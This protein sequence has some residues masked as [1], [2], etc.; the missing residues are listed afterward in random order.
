MKK[1]KFI[2]LVLIILMFSVG[3]A[4][5]DKV[6]DEVVE[7]PK[8]ETVEVVDVTYGDD[9]E[10]YFLVNDE[11]SFGI[12]KGVI[13]IND[14]QIKDQSL[15]FTFDSDFNVKYI[16]YSSSKNSILVQTD[17]YLYNLNLSIYEL[18]ELGEISEGVYG[19]I[20][21][22]TYLNDGYVYTKYNDLDDVY[23]VIFS[24]S[25]FSYDMDIASLEGHVLVDISEDMEMIFYKSEDD[26][27]VKNIAENYVDKID[28]KSII[29]KEIYFGEKTGKVIVLN[30]FDYN[31]L[32]DLSDIKDMYDVV[33]ENGIIFDPESET[34]KFG[35]NIGIENNI[36]SKITKK[37]LN[38]V[39]IIDAS[40]LVVAPG[41]IDML[42]F[43]PN[44]IGAKYKIGDGV[45]TNLSMH[46]CS[47]DFDKFFSYYERNPILINYGG[48]VFMYLIR[49]EAGI[50]RYTEPTQGQIEYIA[51]RTREEIEAGGLG[52]AFSPEYY[53]GTTPEEIKASILVAK[54]YGLAS[55]FHA[56]YSS[57]VGE[58]TSI[59]SVIE[60]VGYARELD[61]HMHFMHL[62]STGAT[63]CMEEALDM[64]N[65]ARDEGYN[66]TF[67][68]YP[69][70]S[71]AT[72]IGSARF[73][74][75]W[76]AKFGIT[77]SDLQIAGTSEFVTEDNFQQLRNDQ[78]IVVAY[79]MDDNEIIMALKED[80][81]MIGSDSI[82]D[83][84]PSFN[85]FRASGAFS[86]FIGRY[87]RDLDIMP[88]MQ[89]IRKTSYLTA[90]QLEDI[91]E[92]MKVRGRIKEGTIAD[93][94]IFDYK[95]IIDTSSAEIPASL[96]K[97]IEY[98]LVSGN[99]I[100]DQ[101]K[102][103]TDRKFGQPIA[104]NFR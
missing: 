62:H 35:Y 65:E 77:Y 1:E 43:N 29:Y 104:N 102:I 75:D 80:Y 31:N 60:I 89:G 7:I 66:I 56:R 53:P 6:K 61:A 83:S 85:H 47:N 92:D 99:I 23:Y 64:I 74:D 58:Y 57:L 44:Y 17:K 32:P 20:L 39:E 21:Y 34:I 22:E 38:A 46:G 18:S 70:D 103:Y 96:S 59:D 24:D 13:S 33:I 3:C 86:R 5:D 101:D 95:N 98:V 48:A 94:T 2:I 41:F 52:L 88:L 10:V 27:Y 97:G 55:H 9:N 49:L 16:D 15:I 28:S 37:D 71:W 50:G 42:S 73:D 36:I 81:S 19:K 40:G 26:F 14:I 45:T 93:I 30:I 51:D 79:A 67:D 12:Y 100:K 8:I 82:V 54:E 78:R 63:G 84:D 72:N 68:I 91:S 87:I 25:D 4:N 76:Q 11:G 69:Y 90:K